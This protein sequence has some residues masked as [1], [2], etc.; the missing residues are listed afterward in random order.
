MPEPAQSPGTELPALTAPPMARGEVIS[1]AEAVAR[2]AEKFGKTLDTLA[3]GIAARGREAAESL[4]RADF[5]PEAQAE[6]GRKAEA[7]ARAEVLP[8]SSDTRWAMLRELQAAADSLSTTALLFATPQAVLARAGLGTPERTNYLAQLEGSGVVQLRNMA[9]FAVATKNAPLG[10]ALL[11]IIDRMPARDRPFSAQELAQR[12]VGEEAAEVTRT[13]E[14]VR[15]TVQRAI[16]ANRDFER[17]RASALDK[18]K[19]ALN[20]KETN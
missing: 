19:V 9:A 16:V 7:K 15:A 6:A 18:V 10:A 2:R 8:N 14:R 1:L 4:A 12:L 3:S 11:T 5:P 13:I 20:S 17:G